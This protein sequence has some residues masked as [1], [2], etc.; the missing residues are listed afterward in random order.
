MQPQFKSPTT[1]AVLKSF[2]LHK[3]K[4]CFLILLAPSK[5][6]TLQIQIDIL[7]VAAKQTLLTGLRRLTLAGRL[8]GVQSS[9]ERART[10]SVFAWESWWQRSPELA[11]RNLV[12]GCPTPALEDSGGVI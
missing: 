12:P 1:P 2:V 7:A 9:P 11:L 3:K 10:P 4:V 8:A 6:A 5:T